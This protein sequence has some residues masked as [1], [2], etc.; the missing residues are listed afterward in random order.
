MTTLVGRNVRIEVSKTEGTAKVVSAVTVAK[1]PVATSTAHGLANGAVG[2]FTDVTGMVNIDGQAARASS[3]DTN[4]FTLAGL[5]ASQYPAF[6]GGDFVP[7]TAWSTLARASGY[8]IGGGDAARQDDTCLLDSIT[9]EINGLL[10]SESI[11]LNLKKQTIDEEALELVRTAARTQ[12]YLVFRITLAD[13]AQR[14][15]RG[16]PSMPGEDVQVGAIGTGSFGVT[17]KGQVVYLPAV[18]A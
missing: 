3:V 12:G 1:P 15:F 2:Y 11:T 7:I 6:T 10:A 9:Q 16:Q 13:G 4:T 14:V 18:S 17:V 8:S 5:D